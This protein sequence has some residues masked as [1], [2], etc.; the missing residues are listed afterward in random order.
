VLL[1]GLLSATGQR[2]KLVVLLA[3]GGL[4]YYAHAGPDELALLEEQAGRLGG[5]GRESF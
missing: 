5:A 2:R 1:P 4:T 3:F